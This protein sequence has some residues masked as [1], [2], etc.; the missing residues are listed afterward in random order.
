M[1]HTANRR[2]VFLAISSVC[3]RLFRQTKPCAAMSTHHW[4]GHH[5]PHGH[6]DQVAHATVGW[7][8]SVK[9][10]DLFQ[11]TCGT[12]QSNVNTERRFGPW[13][14]V[15]DDDELRATVCVLCMPVCQTQYTDG[16]TYR[17]KCFVCLKSCCSCR[18]TLSL[19]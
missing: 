5:N 16:V 6:V 14:R 1:D 4:V 18:P 9:T 19:T 13:R 3:P 8:K 12:R 7:S 2:C 17:S 10:L 11:Q 15:D